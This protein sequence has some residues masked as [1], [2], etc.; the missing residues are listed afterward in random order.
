MTEA[1]I[2]ADLVKMGVPAH[3]AK[4]LASILVRVPAA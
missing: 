3:L 4:Y 1:Q 2:A